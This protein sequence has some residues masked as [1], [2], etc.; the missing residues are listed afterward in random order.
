VISDSDNKTV[1]GKLTE[2]PLT[3]LTNKQAQCNCIMFI[4]QR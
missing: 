4:T 1:S 3:A 2:L